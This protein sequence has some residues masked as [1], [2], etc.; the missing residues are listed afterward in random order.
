MVGRYGE[1]ENEEDGGGED[2]GEEQAKREA[3][4]EE[5]SS[6]DLRNYL[7]DDILET[8]RH[9]QQL[10]GGLPLIIMF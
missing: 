4:E 1:G 10:L 9:L 8:V 2:E 3:C 5:E 7:R 6:L